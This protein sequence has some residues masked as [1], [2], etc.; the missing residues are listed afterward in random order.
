MIQSS[1]Y[2]P[3]WR[4]SF[5]V[6]LMARGAAGAW[7]WSG[8]RSRLTRQLGRW[9]AHLGLGLM[10]TCLAAVGGFKLRSAPT[11]MQ[12]FE[13]NSVGG[14]VH[15]A[16][17]TAVDGATGFSSPYYH[18]ISRSGIMRQAQAH[19]AIPQ[20]PRLE[21]IT[22]TVQVGDT[23]ESIAQAFG[24]QPTTLMWSNPDI[25]KMPD[26]LRVGQVLV[27]LPIDG[28]YHTVQP[29]DTLE[30]LAETY[31][32]TVD[33]IRDCPFNDIP[34]D[35]PLEAGSH[36]VVPGGTK[37]YIERRVTPYTGP[38][39][40]NVEA[41]GLF[42]WPTVGVLTQGYWY[43]HRAIDIGA[44]VGTAVR[45]SDGG[46][47]SFAGWT[48]VGYGYL[49]VIDHSNGYQ[50]YYAHL[51]NIF[52]REGEVVDAGQI[53]GAVGSTGNSTGPHLHFEIRFNHYPTNPLIYLP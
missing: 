29:G 19:T 13:I 16:S 42:R 49:V 38:V 4:T 39:P 33:A 10:L 43:G 9:S 46:F 1:R 3:N 8:D 47:V 5:L 35:G 51:S 45:A 25:E 15:S 27:I 23:A 20:R 31:K 14:S 11:V 24:L 22:Y 18:S 2:G 7:R 53:I 40:S 26:L 50:T 37:P 36:V 21:V 32:V 28:V 12:V 44:P 41:S 30:S 34:E 52:V 17:S 48:D 6:R